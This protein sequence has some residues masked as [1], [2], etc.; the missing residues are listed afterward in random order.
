MTGYKGNVLIQATLDNTPTADNSYY[1]VKNKSYNG[2]SGVD[3][4]NFNGI[5]TYIR[6]VHIPATAPGE[7][8]NNNPNFFGSFDKILYRS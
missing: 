1:T 8:D 2:F 4:V 6:V 3:Y 7:P 5:Y